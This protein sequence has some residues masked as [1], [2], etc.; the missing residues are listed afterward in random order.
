MHSETPTALASNIIPAQQPNR[1]SS[2]AT[3]LSRV[4]VAPNAGNLP[5]FF[6]QSP[7]RPLDFRVLKYCT[8]QM[9]ALV[10]RSDSHA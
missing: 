10:G 5:A 3:R 7:N 9:H 1:V 8:N 6:T 2:Q 4:R